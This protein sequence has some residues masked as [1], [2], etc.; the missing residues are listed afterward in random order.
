MDA[1]Q[2]NLSLD[3]DE[4]MENKFPSQFLESVSD[5]RL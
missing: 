1:I 4:Q 5:S 3:S 2:S